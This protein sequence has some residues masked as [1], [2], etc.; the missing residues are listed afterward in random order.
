MDV[1]INACNKIIGEKKSFNLNCADDENLSDLAS[2]VKRRLSL[3]H[4]LSDASREDDIQD[5]QPQDQGTA[6]SRRSSKTSD[7]LS[8]GIPV[9][10]LN[11][12]ILV[13]GTRGDVSPFVEMGKKLK[14]DFGHTVR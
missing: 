7:L 13:V 2:Y 11:I 3:K 10:K 14:A 4:S 5:N 6:S 1:F 12:I 8:S 9:P